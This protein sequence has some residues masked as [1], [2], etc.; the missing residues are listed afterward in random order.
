GSWSDRCRRTRCSRPPV[1]LIPATARTWLAAATRART[2]PSHGAM[3]L[4][5][6]EA[7]TAR[8]AADGVWP[9]LGPGALAWDRGIGGP[10]RQCRGMAEEGSAYSAGIGLLVLATALGGVIVATGSALAR[11]VADWCTLATGVRADGARVDAVPE[12][13]TLRAHREAV[14]ADRAQGAGELWRLPLLP[15][16]AAALALT[17]V[18]VVLAVQ[19]VAGYA[20]ISTPFAGVDVRGPWLTKA[21]IAVVCLLTAGLTGSGLRRVH[22][23]RMH[24]VPHQPLDAARQAPRPVETP[25]LGS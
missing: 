10:V 1:I 7:I 17:V 13:D 16:T 2:S 8:L 25:A 5:R 3:V 18:G 6:R 19:L 12:P 15:R 20:E 24:R 14:D 11:A 22:R 21:L 23:A 4:R 9:R